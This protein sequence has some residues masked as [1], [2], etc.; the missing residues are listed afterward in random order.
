MSE[1]V[2]TN[3]SVTPLTPAGPVASN[4]AVV[5]ETL[6]VG[7]V[8]SN[9]EM[10]EIAVLVFPDGNTTGSTEADILKG[11]SGADS[12]SGDMGDDS[13][14]GGSGADI[15]NGDEGDDNIK[16]GSGDDI[17][18]GGLGDDEIRLGA[19]E[20]IFIF[21][22]GHGEDLIKDFI[23]GADKIDLADFGLGG[24]GDI[25]SITANGSG[26]A[27]IEPIATGGMHAITLQGIAPAD[28]SGGQAQNIGR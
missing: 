5:G 13:I 6:I 23:V 17:I 14:N 28:L 7:G 1:T 9:T 15:L 18:T 11:G 2:G 10:V 22:T 24:F 12:I 26:D 25:H 20:D 27:V 16:G 19:G 8:V 21:E 3:G 4:V